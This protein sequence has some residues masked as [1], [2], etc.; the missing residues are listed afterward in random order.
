MT[1]ICNGRSDLEYQ[2]SGWTPAA[3]ITGAKLREGLCSSGKVF[4]W[5]RQGILALVLSR[6][7]LH[8]HERHSRKNIFP[9]MRVLFF[10]FFWKS[11]EVVTFGCW[12]EGNKKRSAKL[13]KL[14]ACCCCCYP[15]VVWGAVCMALH[16]SFVH[17]RACILIQRAVQYKQTTWIH[18]FI[19]YLCQYRFFFFLKRDSAPFSRR[20]VAHIPRPKNAVSKRLN[21]W[22]PSLLS[23]RA[24]YDLQRQAE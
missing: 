20:W 23:D 10:F 1:T 9:S 7:H 3:Y 11:K 17:H 15:T 5:R 2:Q 8:L 6:Q 16:L 18:L 22:L 24:S 21:N 12:A 19:R 13:Q 4:H 14:F